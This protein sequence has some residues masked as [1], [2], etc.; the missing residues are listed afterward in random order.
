MVKEIKSKSEKYYQCEECNFIYKERKWAGKCE[1]WCRKNK[2]CNVTITR[3][4]ANI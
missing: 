2:S 4:A 1:Q 3:H